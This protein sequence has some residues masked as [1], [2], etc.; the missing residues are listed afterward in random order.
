MRAPLQ[1]RPLTDEL[2]LPW[3][4]LTHVAETPST[5]AD[6]VRAAGT[7]GAVPW[8]VLVTEHQSAGRGRLGRSWSSAPGSTLTF[9]ALVPTPP[10]PA[11]VP[12]LAGLAVAEAVEE[13]YAVRPALKWPNDVLGPVGSGQEGRKVAGVLCELT[14][15]GI[16]VGIGL[17]VDQDAQELPV[18]T[19]TSLRLLAGG[20]PDG[21]TR[22]RLLLRLLGGLAD[23]LHAWGEDPERVRDAYRRSCST[24]GQEV[25]VDLGEHGTVRG[26]ALEVDVDGHL[27][28]DLDGQVRALAAGDVTHLRSAPL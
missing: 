12:L 14:A 6:L 26:R 11:W 13:L 9:S 17:N 22:E 16:V 4:R 21:L 27:V 3:T 10:A 7:G 24:L 28:L 25:L 19:A 20:H 8:S 2:P 15:A 23:V 5:N 1:V 18:P